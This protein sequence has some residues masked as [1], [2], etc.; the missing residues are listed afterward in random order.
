MPL[1]FI[2]QNVHFYILN[3][4]MHFYDGHCS[5]LR[6]NFVE[7]VLCVINMKFFGYVLV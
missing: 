7:V 1:F 2:S 6:S 4:I 5:Y 3:K